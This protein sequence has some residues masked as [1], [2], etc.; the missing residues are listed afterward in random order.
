MTKI[1]FLS[2]FIEVL[3]MVNYTDSIA[4]RDHE[5]NVYFRQKK[6]DDEINSTVLAA[7]FQRCGDAPFKTS[8]FNRLTGD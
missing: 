3:K 6:P 8:P 1:H 2:G 7:A 4:R 5:N